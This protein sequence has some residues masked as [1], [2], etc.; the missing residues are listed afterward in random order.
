[1]SRLWPSKVG[2]SCGLPGP[3][4]VVNQQSLSADAPHPAEQFKHNLSLASTSRSDTQRRESLSYLTSRVSA[5]PSY[6]P[7]GTST[8]LTKLLPLVSDGSSHVRSQ[9]LELFRGLPPSEVRPHVEKALM[10]IRAGMTHLS[11]D[12]RSDTLNVMDW[13]LDVAGDET[14][15]CPGGWMKTLNSFSAMLGWNPSISSATGSKGWTSA[16]KATLGAVKG[17]QAQARQIQGLVKFLRIGFKPEDPT[18]YKP[19]AYWDNIYRLPRRPNP[20]SYLNLFG[21]ARDEEGEMYPDRESRQ[22]IFHRRWSD[23][24]AKGMEE[25][26]KEGG[27]V[28]RAAASLDQ[29]LKN[30]LGDC[31]RQS[32][33]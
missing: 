3:A 4:I 1:M 19:Q 20:F 18:P 30:G 5:K 24:I 12:I 33:L 11:V 8:I 26:K 32:E 21:P 31:N 13:L 16:S 14:V 25:A 2:E 7:V 27:A 9:L 28:G 29:V 17:G 23:A 10:Y 15:S 22:I 6:N